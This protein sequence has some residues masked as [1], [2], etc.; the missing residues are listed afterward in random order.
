MEESRSEQSNILPTCDGLIEALSD[1]F[2]V[3]RSSVKYRLLEVG[4]RDE[5]SRYDDF[6]AIYEEIIGSKEYA[7]LTPIEAYQ[8]LQE[9]SSLQEWVYG[10]RFVYADG[11]FVLADKE[12]ITAKNGEIL[13]TAK[14]KRNIEKCVLNIHEQK[15]TEYPNFCKDFAGYAMLFQTAGM[16]RRLFSFHPKYQSNIDKLDTDTAY[17]A[18]TN[19]IF[20]DDI[21]DEKEIYKTIVDPTQSLCQILMFIMDK[22]GCDT[23]AKFNHRTLLHKNYYGDIKNDKKNDMKTKTLMAI[24]VGMKLNSRLTQE[25]FKRSVNNYQVYVDPYATYTRIMETLPS[26]PIDDFNEIL[27][28]KGMETLGTEMRDP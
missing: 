9:E 3:S 26:L 27:S 22:R 20:S 1:F 23:S 13:L 19:A 8:L 5:I 28:R 18:A 15:Y 7:K 14:A 6:E 12:Y 25:V 10:G 21:D 4:L 2:I 11:Y 24:C 16:D 17:D